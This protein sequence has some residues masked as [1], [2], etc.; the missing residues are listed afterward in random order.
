MPLNTHTRTHTHARTQVHASFSHSLLRV[1]PYDDCPSLPYSDEGLSIAT[2]AAATAMASASGGWPAPDSSSS[3][4]AIA[5]SGTADTPVGGVAEDAGAIRGGD[6]VRLCHLMST[7]FLTCEVVTPEAFPRGGWAQP[8]TRMVGQAG[9]GGGGR[10]GGG[11]GGVD[12]PVQGQSSD[13]GVGGGPFLYISATPHRR[14]KLQNASSN[15][16]WVLERTHC[17]LGGRPL[18]GSCASAAGAVDPPQQHQQQG[19]NPTASSSLSTSGSG[20]ARR[21]S[22]HQ[23]QTAQQSGKSSAYTGGAAAAGAG[24]SSGGGGGGNRSGATER[25]RWNSDSDHFPGGND[26]GARGNGG[27]DGST[28]GASGTR[29][30]SSF[31]GGGFGR[32]TY[33]EAVA[34]RR[35]RQG[36]GDPVEYVRIKHLATMRYLCV[37]KKCDPV[38]GGGGVNAGGDAGAGGTPATRRRGDSRRRG[39]AAADAAATRVGMLTVDQHAAVPAATVFVIRPRRTA[40]AAAGGLVGPAA[41][42]RVGADRWLG[43]EDLV[44][45]QHKNTGLFLSALPLE[46]TAKG[47]IG[48]TMVKS[49][50]TTEA[51][52]LSFFS[53]FESGFRVL[54]G[55]CW[56]VDA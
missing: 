18:R 29:P 3:P 49:P 47:G 21:N 2:T 36:A 45:L 11:G 34:K 46:N 40:A 1:V 27:G 28:G 24:Y 31:P 51:S 12:G 32:N 13:G 53:L 33:A 8:E 20:N 50:L 35:R 41:A 43:P 14:Q 30:S 4:Y 26:G 44:H 42:E 54:L 6:V 15:C 19:G 9:G 23:Q 10:R 39:A 37:G 38:R 22:H 5:G 56:L 48:L 55:R 16:L 17:A 52:A 25:Q 7:G